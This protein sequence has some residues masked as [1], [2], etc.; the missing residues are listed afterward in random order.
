M[1]ASPSSAS[2]ASAGSP[3]PSGRQLAWETPLPATVLKTRPV[4]AVIRATANNR[5]GDR[6]VRACE[7]N[8]RHRA[9][10]RLQRR[11]P[12][13]VRAR[14]VSRPAAATPPI[15]LA[16][17]RA[18][19]PIDA[20]SSPR[21][22]RSAPKPRP[23]A[24]RGGGGEEYARSGAANPVDDQSA[25]RWSA[26]PNRRRGRQHRRPQGGFCHAAKRERRA[27]WARSGPRISP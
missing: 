16:T 7:A 18:A 20:T 13:V 26:N 14:S 22:T 24:V 19:M 27:G 9:T 8:P 11:F 25:H 2:A 17:R 10:A 6:V 23:E 4:P 1:R 5:L 3:P 12:A 15:R 21:D